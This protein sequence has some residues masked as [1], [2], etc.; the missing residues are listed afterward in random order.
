MVRVKITGVV[1]N[2]PFSLGY[3][4]GEEAL[5]TEDVAKAL[6]SAGLATALQ[7]TAKSAVAPPPETKLKK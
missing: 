1:V 5:V 7:E 6:I 2:P 4:P 3:T